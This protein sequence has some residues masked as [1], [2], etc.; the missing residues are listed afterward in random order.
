MVFKI[1]VRQCAF[2]AGTPPR[3]PLKSHNA[4]EIPSQLGR[5][6]PLHTPP[7][8]IIPPS[9][10]ATSILGWGGGNATKYFLEPRGATIRLSP[11]DCS[12]LRQPPAISRRRITHFHPV[13]VCNSRVKIL[14]FQ[15]G[16]CDA[17]FHCEYKETLS[18][19]TT[20]L[21]TNPYKTTPSKNLTINCLSTFLIYRM[22][23]DED[24][25]IATDILQVK[26]HCQKST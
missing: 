22:T 7:H 17:G 20:I 14:K 3:T 24:N 25:N 19:R 2:P 6:T 11:N 15:F 4:P 12:F 9:V 26:S 5:G 13:Y 16:L 21:R 8:S 23:N 18:V 1:H 10:L